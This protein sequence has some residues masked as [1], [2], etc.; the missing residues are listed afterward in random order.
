[1]EQQ[2]W[3]RLRSI[4][5]RA[6]IGSSGGKPNFVRAAVN[7]EFAESG[8]WR[9]SRATSKIDP[10]GI[11]YSRYPGGKPTSGATFGTSQD[12]SRR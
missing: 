5:Y 4:L 10:V 9:R 6:E 8:R 2:L 12:A 7:G 11:T 1:L 3:V